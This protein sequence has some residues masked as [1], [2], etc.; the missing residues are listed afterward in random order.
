MANLSPIDISKSI[1]KLGNTILRQKALPWTKDEIRDRVKVEKI[2]ETLSREMVASS[3]TGIA[4][5]QIGIPK[6][7]FLFE[8]QSKRDGLQCPEFPLTAFFNPEIH[9][10]EDEVKT[11]KSMFGSSKNLMN[12]SKYKSK[13]Q[14]AE[15]SLP[16]QP[17][18]QNT[19][20]IWESCLSI[21]NFYAPVPRGRKCIIKFLDIEANE[22][23]I[24]CDGIVAA[25][26]QHENDHLLGKVFADRLANPLNDL[27]YISELTT[28]QISDI[29]NHTGDFQIVK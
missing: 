8:L 14:T 12:L 21:P 17:T 24:E 13:L 1:I 20:K 29:F 11:P 18:S 22:R 27:I 2:L 25:C 19:I 16:S 6:Q 9:I 5:P 10:I 23:V 7:L 28:E 26:L 15:S 3:G 4:A